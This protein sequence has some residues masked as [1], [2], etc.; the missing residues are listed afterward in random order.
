MDGERRER[1]RGIA[2]ALLDVARHHV[3]EPRGDLEAA[4]G[5]VPAKPADEKL[6]DGLAKLVLDRCTFEPEPTFDPATLR[7]ALF[8]R[9]TR[10]RREGTTESRDA[11]V[12]EVGE[13]FGLSEAEVEAGLYA[14]LKE[15]H[16]LRAFEDV[17]PAVLV[18]EYEEAL[19]QAV[20][21]RA[22]RVEVDVRPASP[23][24]LRALL[25]RLKFLRLLFAVAAA[26]GGGHRLV[27]E[28]PL[29]MFDGGARYGLK[30]AM[31]L[32]ALRNAGDFELAAEVRWGKEHALCTFRVKGSGAARGVEPVP[33]P[34]DAQALLDALRAAKTE[35]SAGP[36]DRVMN[37]PGLGIVVPDLVLTR[38]RARVYVEV[39]GFW[40][41]EAVWRRVELAERG[42]PD[43]IVFVASERLRVSEEVLESEHAS[44]F[45]YKGVISPKKLLDRVEKLSGRG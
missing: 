17:S 8:R 42:L 36:A 26:E 28:G 25:H 40:S 39:L 11:I 35:W 45:V 34:D 33:L 10:W 15:A 32:S 13:G 3:G 38:G 16:P 19:P 30:L 9:A 29:A 24:A 22:T 27:V 1:A 21:L 5:E 7:D 20:L 31:L 41:R 14:D 44:L 6:R 12:R 23:A 18:A 2:E 4:L 43:K 37:L